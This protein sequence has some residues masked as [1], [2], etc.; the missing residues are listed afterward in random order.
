MC[1]LTGQLAACKV[2]TAENKRLRAALV[3]ARADL[4]D[5]AAYA[6]EYIQEKWDLKG[7]L[8]RIDAVLGIDG[9]DHG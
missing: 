2:C 6:S 1:E 8:A 3:E 4:A 5:W 9:V 7:D